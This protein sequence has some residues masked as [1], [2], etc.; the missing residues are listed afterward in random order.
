MLRIDDNAVIDA[1]PRDAM[2]WAAYEED[3]LAFFAL[4]DQLSRDDAERFAQTMARWRLAEPYEDIDD[5]AGAL[6]SRPRDICSYYGIDD[7]ANIDFDDAV[8][9]AQRHQFR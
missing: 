1:V 7:A 4:A 9:L 8:E 3:G 2:T 5:G 6:R